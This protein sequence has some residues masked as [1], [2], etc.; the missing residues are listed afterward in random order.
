MCADQQTIRVN[1]GK[2][3]P[4]FPLAGVVLLPHAVLPLHIFEERY[5]QMVTDA[6]DGAGLIALATYEGERWRQEYSGSP[7]IRPVVCVGQIAQHEKLFDGR[8]N[9]L[10]QGVCR[11]RVVD[12]HPPE[13]ERL[14][15][16][17]ALKPLMWHGEDDPALDLARRRIHELLA[18]PPLEAL[19][20]S[21]GIA[22]ALERED[23]PTSALLELVGISVISDAEMK[24]RLLEEAD[25][26]ARAELIERELR[27]LRSLLARAERQLD[28]EAPR[29]VTWN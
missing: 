22:Q 3:M 17:A 2:P 4:I 21:E 19:S 18:S 9:I 12:E 23:A 6:L 8:Y 27:C 26:A 20:A 25:P 7:P 14:Y 24:Y 10:L 11:A 16:Q 15:R 13:G 5:R 1:F 29:G 28:P